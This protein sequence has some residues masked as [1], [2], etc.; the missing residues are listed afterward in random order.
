MKTS[1]ENET[2]FVSYSKKGIKNS[3]YNDV[4]FDES[5][6][7]EIRNPNDYILDLIKKIRVLTNQIKEEGDDQT[8][9][10][11][12]KEKKELKSQLP[13]FSMAKFKDGYR[14]NDNFDSTQHMILDFDKIQDVESLK[15]KFEKDDRIFLIFNSP[16]GD[17]L[18]VILCFDQPIK[19][20]KKFKIISKH[21]AQVFSKEYEV[22]VDNIFDAAR[23][24]Y[25][26]YDPYL[27]KNYSCEKLSVDVTP[28]NTKNINDEIK[29]KDKSLINN[30]EGVIEGGRNTALVKHIG[31]CIQNG[32][33]REF[34]SWLLKEWNKKNSPPLDEEEVIDAV[35]DV[36]RRYNNEITKFLWCDAN[37]EK[38]KFN[39]YKFKL[40]LENKGYY[41]Y[42]LSSGYA[43]IRIT[44]KHCKPS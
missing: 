38:L 35:N 41:K 27:H 17:G 42:K 7:N 5:I 23:A 16:S 12:G 40:F 22:E 32:K 18:K 30:W 21:Y 8:R 39:H 26:S 25:I 15:E 20:V 4:N 33:E 6:V 9:R 36:Y 13:H 14:S 3:H 34:A 11:M 28:S 2:I 44:K 19:S 31:E 37:N 10:E 24:C 43:I 1:K 29:P